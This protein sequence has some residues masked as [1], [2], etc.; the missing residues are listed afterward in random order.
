[1]RSAAF[2]NSIVFQQVHVA[3]IWKLWVLWLAT[4]WMFVQ[5]FKL[6]DYLDWNTLWECSRCQNVPEE[7]PRPLNVPTSLGLA[8]LLIRKSY[9]VKV[10][11][12]D[13]S[14]REATIQSPKGSLQ[15][16][17]IMFCSSTEN[18]PITLPWSLGWFRNAAMGNT[19]CIAASL[20][21]LANQAVWVG[22]IWT[23][24]RG[25]RSL[26]IKSGS[27]LLCTCP[28]WYWRRYRK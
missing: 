20:L 9:R 13:W 27:C 24:H 8:T 18:V 14:W 12:R 28:R 23:N 22:N 1:M 19:A 16:S 10:K 15:F 3:I 5:L 6:S 2:S 17:S 7:G 4:S 26:G 21:Y 25:R 11:F